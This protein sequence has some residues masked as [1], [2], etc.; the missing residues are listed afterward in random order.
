MQKNELSDE[1]ANEYIS[2]YVNDKTI[3]LNTDDEK[4]LELMYQEA[5]DLGLLAS[6][7]II[8]MV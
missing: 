7:P 3:A 6:K 8:D 1:K 2:M 4:S 5:T